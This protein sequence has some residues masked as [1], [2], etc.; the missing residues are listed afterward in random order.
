MHTRLQ[1]HEKADNEV[2]AKWIEVKGKSDEIHE[3]ML[4]TKADPKEESD[5]I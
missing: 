5:N 2:S 1:S 4:K 3:L